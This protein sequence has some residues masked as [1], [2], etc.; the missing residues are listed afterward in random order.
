M[1]LQQLSLNLKKEKETNK[2]SSLL[3][4]RYSFQAEKQFYLEEK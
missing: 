3:E 2:V 1:Q 4:S